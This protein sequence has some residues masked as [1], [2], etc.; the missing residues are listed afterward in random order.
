M[1]QAN[2]DCYDELITFVNTLHRNREFEIFTAFEGKDKKQNNS[3]TIPTVMDGSTTD[4]DTD[5]GYRYLQGLNNEKRG[6]WFTAN[7]MQY[8]KRLTE[9]INSFNALV[10]DLDAGKEGENASIVEEKKQ[11]DLKLLLGLQL[12]P[13][14]IVET[15]NGLQPYWF[16]LDGEITDNELYTALQRSMV[17]KLGADRGAIGGERLY[18]L[19]GFYHWKDAGDPFLCKIIHKDYSKRYTLKELTHKFGGQKKLA[20]LKKKAVSGRYTGKAIELAEFAHRG[21]IAGIAKGCSVIRKLEQQKD[22][23]HKERLALVLIY[24][25]LGKAGLDHFREIARGWNDYNEDITE[26]MIRHALSQGYKPTACKAFMDSGVCKGRC[27]NILDKHSPIAFYYNPVAALPC[28]FENRELLD[29]GTLPVSLDDKAVRDRLVKRFREHDQN[30]S[31]IHQEILL[32]ATGV[33]SLLPAREKPIVIPFIPGGGKTSLIVEYL[34]YMTSVTS[35]DPTFGAI[36]V[37]ERQS[38]I[39]DIAR[40]I[41]T[42][43]SYD[44]FDNLHADDLNLAYPLIGYSPDCCLKGYPTY[45]P[46]Q[47]KTCNVH[48]NDCRVKYNHARQ[49]RFPVVVISHARLFEM[50][51]RDDLMSSLRHWESWRRTGDGQYEKTKHQRRL[52]ILDEKPKLIDNIP[53]DSKMWNKL[54]TDVQE[55][56]PKHTEEVEQAIE[57]VRGSYAHVDEYQVVPSAEEKFKWSKDFFEDW[58]KKYLGD[59]PN[60]PIFLS[61]VI[62]EGG[63]YSKQDNSISLTHYSNTYWGDYN[64]II[65][66]GTAMTDPD[67]RDDKFIFWDIPHLRPYNNL[68]IN[69]CMEQNLSKTFYAKHPDFVKEFCG[70]IKEIAA[71]GKTYL[72]SYKGYEKEFQ[73]NLGD[74]ENIRLEHWGNTK[75]RNDLMDCKNIVCA[76]LLHKGESYYHS[77]DISI[78][79]GRADDRSFNCVTTGKVRRFVDIQTEATKVYDFLTEL[80]QD[81]FRTG[82]RNHYSQ[83]EINVYLCFRDA[84]LINLLEEFFL[85]CTINRDWK[86]KA[87]LN[88]RELFREFCDEHGD[89]YNTKAKLVKAFIATGKELTTEDLCEVLGISKRDAG[90]MLRRIAKVNKAQKV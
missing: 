17:E 66:D 38:T 60:Y 36:F 52:L 16:L 81:I 8:G 74:I 75:G 42:S 64:T 68:K 23:N 58:K 83:E 11:K 62:A 48:F 44:M 43:Y 69:I 78:H 40:D 1:F 72:V 49:K 86:P 35:V 7:S 39:Q 73:D 54:L 82:L 55:F 88:N 20:K 32:K 77:K 79:G 41:N 57:K 47:C 6:I 67:Y 90:K 2:S 70:D 89:E 22:L 29:E 87:L 46:S 30:L 59:H 9:L 37:V 31:P 12:I 4:P 10:V 85:G 51:D 3:F 13:T 18:R 5:D 21:D 65:L 34:R 27:A 28:Q 76:G 26:Y 45:K 61:R 50:S 56:T 24:V 53:T 80:I 71:S 15:K 14:V 84:N 63:L 25:N 19:P 33:M